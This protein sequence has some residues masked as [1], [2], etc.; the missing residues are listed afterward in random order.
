MRRPSLIACVHFQHIPSAPLTLAP[1]SPSTQMNANA[2][3]AASVPLPMSVVKSNA[4]STPARP[5][6]A[7]PTSIK[8]SIEARQARTPA[9]K[10]AKK[11]TALPSPLRS[12]IKSRIAG[13]PKPVNS[14]AV[15]FVADRLMVESYAREVEGIV[16]VEKPVAIECALDA[17]MDNVATTKQNESGLVV[18]SDA[19][20]KPLRAL[21]AD[22]RSSIVDLKKAVE[23]KVTTPAVTK[24]A[25]EEKEEEEDADDDFGDDLEAMFSQRPEDVKLIDEY[26]KDFTTKAG[27]EEKDAYGYAL[28]AY[29]DGVR[30]FWGNVEAIHDD[31]AKDVNETEDKGNDDTK[32][33]QEA[34]GD[35]AAE[36]IVNDAEESEELPAM[37]LDEADVEKTP[38]PTATSSAKRHSLAAD[39]AKSLCDLFAEHDEPPEAKNVEDDRSAIANNI[40]SSLCHLLTSTALSN[41][42]AKEVVEEAEEKIGGIAEGMGEGIAKLIKSARKSTKKEMKE[43]TQ[44]I[45]TEMAKNLNELFQLK[46]DISIKIN[47][48]A[49]KQASMV[50]L[51]R[52]SKKVKVKRMSL[53]AD[54]AES[55][56][57][58]FA[59]PKAVYVASGKKSKVD[60]RKSLAADMGDSLNLLFKEQDT[61]KSAAFDI[62]NEMNGCLVR[63]FEGE[64]VRSAALH[65]GGVGGEVGN[66]AS[67]LT[68]HSY[69][70]HTRFLKKRRRMLPQRRLQI[71]S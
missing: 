27:I 8:K 17:Y 61:E 23:D 21:P 55:L 51:P 63:L 35:E 18:T 64:E 66:P 39:M 22:L 47:N 38:V 11:A 58:L 6:A 31:V 44:E 25:K 48:D 34:Q 41:A 54:M 71:L 29:L 16:D 14:V 19:E 24:G 53:A 45:A 3:A 12:A 49:A 62:F 2:S 33:V 36:M 40:A 68:S 1:P 37:G 70:S 7:F 9:N 20:A 50:P 15:D 56:V 60:R 59:S 13:E 57:G 69:F 52:S 67:S 32:D 43:E 4:P 26:A 28:D 30:E 42:T 5:S 65:V 10:S 46:D